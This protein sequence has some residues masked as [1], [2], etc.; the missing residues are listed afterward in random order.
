MVSCLPYI[1]LF[2]PISPSPS[3]PSF[4]FPPPAAH[5]F[6]Y[7]PSSVSD[8]PYDLC[9]PSPRNISWLTKNFL[10]IYW[11]YSMLLL[12]HLIIYVFTQYVFIL[13][14]ISFVFPSQFEFNWTIS[15]DWC[16]CNNQFSISFLILHLFLSLRVHPESSSSWCINFSNH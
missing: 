1:H 11:N 9:H 3:P 15:F 6:P 12:E 13:S 10:K 7:P 8:L 4:P 16:I 5:F 14:D 2:L